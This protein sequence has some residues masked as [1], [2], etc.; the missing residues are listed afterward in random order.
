M[1]TYLTMDYVEQGLVHFAGWQIA[2]NDHKF[3]PSLCVC[4]L[5]CKFVVS[6]I[7]EIELSFFP[8]ESVLGHVTCFGQQDI[9]SHDA[10]KLESTWGLPALAAL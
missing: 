7:K 3:F 2:K 9:H 5:Y 6:V 4:P 1:D 8:F 10:S